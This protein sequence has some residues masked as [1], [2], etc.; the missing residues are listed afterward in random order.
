MP[1]KGRIP[2]YMPDI[3]IKFKVTIKL[4]EKWASTMSTEELINYIKDKLNEALGFRG[5][6]KKLSVVNE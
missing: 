5:Q 6:I 2:N 1:I 3:E 4:S